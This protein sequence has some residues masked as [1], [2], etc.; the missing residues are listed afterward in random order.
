MC[1]SYKARAFSCLLSQLYSAEVIYIIQSE[2]EKY[3]P[4]GVSYLECITAGNE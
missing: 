3:L 2:R 4:N 1:D